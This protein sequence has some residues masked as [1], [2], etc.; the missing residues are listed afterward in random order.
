[1]LLVLISVRG[2]VDLRAIVRSEGLCQW[3]IPMTL[4]GIEPTTLRFVAQRL[5]NCAT[6]VPPPHVISYCKYTFKTVT[7]AKLEGNRW[8]WTSGSH[9]RH[10]GS[11]LRYLAHT[12]TH[13]RHLNW[14]CSINIPAWPRCKF[15]GRTNII[16]S[17][18]K[19]SLPFLRRFR[20]GSDDVRKQTNIQVF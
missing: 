13:T 10:I 5:N 7:S 17:W 14:T 8:I 16:L 1:M 19:F 12:H 4:S 15:W 3:K 20:L 11:D 6:A 18:I 9:S 2:W